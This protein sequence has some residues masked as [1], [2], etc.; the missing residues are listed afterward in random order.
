[1]RTIRRGFTLLELMIAIGLMLIVM[2]MLRTMFVT[3]Q[4]MYVRASR[5]VDVY[6]QARVAM[7]TMEQDL[8][9]MRPGE[10]AE[11]VLAL[12]SL[13]PDDMESPEAAR[14]SEIYVDMQDWVKE[15]P[16]ET[17]K[18]RE[19]LL[20]AARSTWYDAKEQRYVTGD[21]IV[22]YYLRKRPPVEGQFSEGG[23][24]VRRL[25]PVR[26]LAE[27]VRILKGAN[28][29]GVSELAPHEDELAAFV[30][31]VKVFVDDQAAFQLGARNGSFSY[32]TMPEVHKSVKNSSWV[33]TARQPGAGPAAKGPVNPQA[34][35]LSL[36]VPNPEERAEFG[37]IWKT[38]TAPDRDFTSARWNYPAVVMLDLTM[39]DRS[40]ERYDQTNGSGTYRSFARAVHL[41]VSGPMSRLDTRDIELMMK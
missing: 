2:L 27:Q 7:D 24:L 35:L 8:M 10:G 11:D 30:Y 38:N 28:K 18:I 9:R 34:A 12:R 4:E 14:G 31:S 5:R 26:S 19:F 41:P 17:R 25:L 29:A 36:P 6:Q 15:D 37:G 39:I 40:L 21:A 16:E 33:W 13:R 20:F 3:A 22:A 1:M 23:Y 32:D